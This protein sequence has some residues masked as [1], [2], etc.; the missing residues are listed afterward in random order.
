[1]T[2][3][4]LDFATFFTVATMAAF[5]DPKPSE[6]NGSNSEVR[7]VAKTAF[8]RVKE[9]EPYQPNGYWSRRQVQSQHFRR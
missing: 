4:K 2:A 7:I 1:M 9:Q 5:V 3:P 8:K 6:K